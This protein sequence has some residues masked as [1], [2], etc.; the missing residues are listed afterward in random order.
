MTH[1]P[2]D[3]SLEPSAR[4]RREVPRRDFLGLA[5]LWSFLTT[6][7]VM[8]M[9]ALR[10]PMPSLFPETGA[11]F[12]IG[13]PDRFPPGSRTRLPERGILVLR[14]EK[15]FRALDLVCTHLG[16]ITR[17]EPDGSFA[18]PCHGSRFDAEGNVVR[19]PAP[20]RLRFLAISRAPNGDLVVD[21]GTAV[22]PDRWTVA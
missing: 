8:T 12:R 7:V 20:S 4:F 9:G 3:P 13:P 18:C 14:D 11:K 19:G 10:L 15:G 2:K 21:R 1:P 17:T 16:C 22:G 5:A 6:G